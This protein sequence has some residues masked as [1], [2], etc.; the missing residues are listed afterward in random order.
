MIREQLYSAA[1]VWE[2]SHDSEHAH[3]RFELSEGELLI[4]SPAGGEHGVVASR[5]DR[6][7]GNFVDEY[8]LGYVT[9]AETGYILATNPDTLRAPDV[10]FVQKSRL[11]DGLP[12]GYI[13][14]APDLAVEVVSPNDQADEIQ[15]KTGEYLRH[16]TRLVWVVYPRTKSVVVHTAEKAITVSGDDMLDGGA[17][18]PGFSLPVAELF[19]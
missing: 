4:M 1:Q 17:V 3:Q 5:L 9:A 16:G 13:P 7:I 2:L 11:P 12:Q 6:K 14:L 19:R 10:G 18:L 15:R 8:D